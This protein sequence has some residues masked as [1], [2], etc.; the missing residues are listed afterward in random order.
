MADEAQCHFLRTLAQWGG[1]ATSRQ[2][3][4]FVL[5]IFVDREQDRA[6]Q[7]CRRQGLVTFE[8]GF[9]RVTEKGREAVR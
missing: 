2:L 4:I 3:G 1:I 5:G 7:K 8:G 9:W 6:R